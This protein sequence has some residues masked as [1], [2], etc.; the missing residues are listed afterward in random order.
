MK[1]SEILEA[2]QARL[3]EFHVTRRRPPL[4]RDFCV[5]VEDTKRKRGFHT[6]AGPISE[7]TPDRVELFARRIRAHME[8]AECLSS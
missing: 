5:F 7:I 8:Q 3:P 4:T 1:E 2:L 6:Q